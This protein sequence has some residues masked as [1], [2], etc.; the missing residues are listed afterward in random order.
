ME[1]LW[2]PLNEYSNENRLIL[3]GLL[4]QRSLPIADASAMSCNVR[5]LHF[6]LRRF[7]ASTQSTIPYYAHI[8]YILTNNIR[9]AF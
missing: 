7:I 1:R 3:Q 9:N 4:H 5:I 2:P 6:R 8:M